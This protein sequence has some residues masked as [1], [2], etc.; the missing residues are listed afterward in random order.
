MFFRC[1]VLVMLLGLLVGCGEW[2]PLKNKLPVYLA[3]RKVAIEALVEALDEAPFGRLYCPQCG[4][5]DT[6]RTE[7]WIDGHW[8]PVENPEAERFVMLLHEAGVFG[9]GKRSDGAYDLEVHAYDRSNPRRSTLI[10]VLFGR[11]DQSDGYIDCAPEHRMIT[12][13]TCK[14]AVDHELW[15]RYAWSPVEWP[16][17][18]DAYME[19]GDFEG[20]TNRVDE[21]ER[22]CRLEGY[23]A[24]GYEVPE[25]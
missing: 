25:S 4:V 17:D 5:D 21:L 6:I 2:P 11:D 1:S 8:H 19:A 14:V 16:V 18:I 7:Q 3:E 10:Q 12:C 22:Q 20:Y 24:I 23:A 15:I 9:I 13:G